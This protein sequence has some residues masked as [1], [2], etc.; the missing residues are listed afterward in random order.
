MKDVIVLRTIVNKQWDSPPGGY[1][2]VNTDSTKLP[3]E[4]PR[5]SNRLCHA[6]AWKQNLSQQTFSNPK[7]ANNFDQSSRID[8]NDAE[9]TTVS[10]N[11]NYL[12]RKTAKHFQED[13]EY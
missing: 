7:L 3:T 4:G 8:L 5:V 13:D 2:Q 11:N 12:I 10:L 9:Y 6:L 1:W